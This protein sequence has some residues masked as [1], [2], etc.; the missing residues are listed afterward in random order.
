VVDRDLI[1]RKLAAID[2]YLAQLADYRQIDLN[3][4]RSDWR[5]QRVVERTL[6]LA[7]ETCMDIADHVVADRCLRVP[8]SGADT[9]KVLA[10]AGLVEPTLGLAL[11]RMVGFRN[12][13]V[14]DYARVDPA[15]V[16]RVLS[17]DLGDVEKFRAA[18]LRL[19]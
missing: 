7:I 6:H 13:L 19:V 3:A 15:I 10:D 8:D 5:T 16:L 1:L 9:F 18:V 4:Y 12:V 17:T 14:H 11:A 2:E